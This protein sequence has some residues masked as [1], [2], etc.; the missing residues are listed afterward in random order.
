MKEPTQLFGFP[1]CTYLAKVQMHRYYS[2]PGRYFKA[3][4]AMEFFDTLLNSPIP[5]VGLENPSGF[6]NSNYCPPDQ[7]LSPVNFG[8]PYRKEICLWLKGFPPLIHTC[9]YHSLVNT[10]LI[11]SMVACPRIR[12]QKSNQAGFFIQKQPKP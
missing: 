4:R 12:N 6:L 1:P 11:M 7:I 8:D 5:L 9:Q 10:Y 3:L 2:E